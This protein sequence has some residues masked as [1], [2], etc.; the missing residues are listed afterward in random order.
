M[1]EKEI[2]DRIVTIIQER[3]GEDFVVTESL[4]LKDDLD[5]DSVDL[6]EF[7]LTL[8]D[9]FNIEISDEEIDQL[10]SVGDVVE[11]VKSKEQQEA[12]CKSCCFFIVRKIKNLELLVGITNRQIRKKKEGYLCM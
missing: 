1:T 10:Q 8:E 9:E 11:V 12:T 4:S 3:Q 7:I 2:F 5:A 6:M